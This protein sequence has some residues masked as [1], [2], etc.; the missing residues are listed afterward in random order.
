MS[1]VWEVHGV[2]NRSTGELLVTLV[3]QGSKIH[4]S[5]KSMSGATLGPAS[6][7]YIAR[8]L[9]NLARQAEKATAAKTVEPVSVPA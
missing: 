2:A 5:T 7:R 3:L 6:A 8:K 4:I 9:Y 1:G